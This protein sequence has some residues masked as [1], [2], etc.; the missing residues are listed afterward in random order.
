MFFYH[1][2]T[3]TIPWL[4][5]KSQ[6]IS[7]DCLMTK[8]YKSFDWYFTRW[9]GNI[10]VCTV[11]LWLYFTRDTKYKIELTKPID[12]REITIMAS[13]HQTLLDPP[14]VFAALKFGDLLKISPVKFMTWHKYYN[15]IYKFPLYATGCYPSHGNGFTGVKGAVH[16]AKNGYRSF[17]FPEGKRTRPNNRGDAYPGVSEI[18]SQ[19]PGARLILVHLDW[20]KRKSLMSRPKLLIHFF[21]ASDNLDRAN[22]NEIMNAI[23]NSN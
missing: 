14:A 21:D 2:S 13:N 22:P 8:K 17:I 16:F 10:A 20:E 6:K 3:I 12:S 4:L 15:S 9:G 5:F 18:L 11:R 1:I 7:Y 23:Y 19:V